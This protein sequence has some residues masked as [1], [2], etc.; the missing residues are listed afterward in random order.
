[1]SGGKLLLDVFTFIL[2]YFFGK[3]E[4]SVSWSL[5]KNDNNKA[6]FHTKSVGILVLIISPVVGMAGK[7]GTRVCPRRLVL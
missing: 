1:M 7:T 6:Y 3:R 4:R 5:E 2:P